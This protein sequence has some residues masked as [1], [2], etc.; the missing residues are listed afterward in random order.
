MR[1]FGSSSNDNNN[2]N[3]ICR[4][5]WSPKMQ[6]HYL[7]I[8]IS[9]VVAASLQNFSVPLR[10]SEFSGHHVVTSLIYQQN[11]HTFCLQ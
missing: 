7:L 10:L 6:R 11:L 2:N 1:V 5:P 3:S 4:A 9:D 8:N